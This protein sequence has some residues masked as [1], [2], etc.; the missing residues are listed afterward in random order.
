MAL[1]K[2]QNLLGYL[3]AILEGRESSSDHSA[4]TASGRS[5]STSPLDEALQ[6]VKAQ[7]FKRDLML[8][9][10][11]EPTAPSFLKTIL[12][13]VDLLV[14]PPDVASVILDL[15]SIVDQVSADYNRQRILN[16]EIEEANGQV[17][18]AW[19]AATESASRVKDLSKAQEARQKSVEE[20]DRDNAQ[21]RVQIAELEAKIAAN[22]KK[23]EELLAVNNESKS[24]EELTEGLRH[25][26]RA[27]SL[28]AKLETLHQS[29]ALC[30]RQ[31]ELQRIK[32]LQIKA[33]LPF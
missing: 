4:S 28:D 23:K 6:K 12:K 19:H 32:Y 25:V 24:Q 3:T 7:I 18:A 22:D 33:N 14:A 5:T 15:L 27:Q 20:I 21:L 30:D 16:R 8:T 2:Q 17:A 10:E 13:V 26:D 1:L 29:K 11:G 31:L 9:L